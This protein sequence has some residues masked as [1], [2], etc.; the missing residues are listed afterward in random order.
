MSDPRPGPSGR[1]ADARIVGLVR[2]SRR[3]RQLPLVT[4]RW[5]TALR[6]RWPGW[7]PVWW[8]LRFATVNFSV[9]ALLALT[10]AVLA[11]VVE[12]LLPLK[13]ADRTVSWPRWLALGVSLVGLF[14]VIWWRSTVHRHTGTLFYLRVLDDAMDDRHTRPVQVARDRRMSLR[15]VTRWADLASRTRHGVIDMVDIC[16]E[17][18]RELEAVVNSDRDDTGYTIAANLFWPVAFAVG[19][20]LPIVDGLHLLE[21]G[22]NPHATGPE[23]LFPLP[24]PATAGAVRTRTVT[25]EPGAARVGLLLAFTRTAAGQDPARIMAGT[26]VGVC[27]VLRPAWIDEDLHGLDQ[28]TFTANQMSALAAALPAAIAEIKNAVADQELVVAG[29]LTKTLA[30]ATGWG[31]AQSTCRFF[32]GTHLLHYQQDSRKYLPM[33]VHPAQPATPATEQPRT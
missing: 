11:L 17:V 6:R 25:I 32:T 4:R 33:R 24:P 16:A 22:D 28:T 9:A 21:L 19:A 10:A 12:D 13:A 15:S 27:H 7:R 30:I 31:L 18:A 29:F 8:R 3:A 20:E 1:S 26:G 5:W 14:A 23:T 2:W